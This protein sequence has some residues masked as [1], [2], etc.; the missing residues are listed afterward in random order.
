MKQGEFRSI[1]K[2]V[3][4]GKVPDGPEDAYYNG[5]IKEHIEFIT[6]RSRKAVGQ[7]WDGN[8]VVENEALEL[9][10][11]ILDK[12]KEKNYKILKQFKGKAK[13]S[14]YITAVI[15]NQ[16]VDLVRRKKGRGREKERAKKIGVWGERIYELIFAAGL[17][18]P[19]AYSEL[20][21]KSGFSGSMDEVESIAAKIKGK[22]IPPGEIPSPQGNRLVQD[23]TRDM[24][25][26]EFIIA[27]TQSNPEDI[28]IET[29]RLKKLKEVTGSIISQLKGEERLILRMRF[30]V[31]EGEKPKEI[32]Q[33]AGLLGISKKAVY[34]RL[35]RVLAKCRDKITRAG[36]KLDDLF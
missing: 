4:G 5:I 11:K 7:M 22:R 30:P 2:P 9:A 29:Q 19:A 13:L 33:I 8:I 18:I 20:K 14:T 23:G 27:D 16:A 15:S 34:N 31:S 32:E 10:N 36:V 28:T 21:S 6:S 3:P 17:E 24:E 26:G 25:T 1:L 35:S 12:L